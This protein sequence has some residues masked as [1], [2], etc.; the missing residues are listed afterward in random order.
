MLGLLKACVVKVALLDIASKKGDCEKYGSTVVGVSKQSYWGQASSVTRVR[1]DA[2]HFLC[3]G[4]CG[5]LDL[6]ERRLLPIGHFDYS[7]NLCK[8]GGPSR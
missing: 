7:K 1:L 3:D 8:F 5:P 6:V 2:T 4:R